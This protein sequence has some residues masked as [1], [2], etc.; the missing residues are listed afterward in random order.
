MAI[1][2][3]DDT[4]AIFVPIIVFWISSGI[5]EL[6]SYLRPD[7][8]LHSKEEE[9]QLNAIS[10]RS[11]IKSA[12]FL[13]AVQVLFVSLFLKMMGSDDGTAISQPSIPLFVLQFFIAMVIVDTVQYFSHRYIHMNKFCYNNFHS[14]HHKLVVPYAIAS[15]Y[16]HPL[17]GPLN[18][19]VSG[20]LA[21][22][23][24]GMTARTSMYFFSFATFRNVDLHCGL[25]LPWSPTQLLFSN[26]QA[27][28][29][30]HH[31]LKGHRYNFASPFFVAWDKILG[32]YMP[33]KV[34]KRMGG[35]YEV[36]PIKMK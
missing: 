19:T 32:T 23:L 10:R 26:N 11:V 7:A 18:D 30:S 14:V 13:Q 6:L 35:G 4:L 25:W 31:Q 29:D 3:S 27:Y 34:E 8:R 20:L 2:F 22:G 17:D 28:H 12:L 1:R 21:A 9:E 15:Q 16:T 24:T 5:Y 36:R 33:Y